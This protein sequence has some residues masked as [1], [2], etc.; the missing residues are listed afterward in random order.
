LALSL[1][2]A[3]QRGLRQ[4]L[5][6]VLG[7]QNTHLARA[8]ELR[9]R[10]QMRPNLTG[11]IG[12]TEQQINLASYGFNFHFPGFSIPSIIGPF[13][14]F[15]AR[16]SFS[17]TLLNFQLRDNARASEH[18]TRAAEFTQ[19][20][21]REMVVLLVA[22]GYLQVVADE[23]R[24]EEARTEVK[25]AAALFE[26]AQDQLKAGLAP[27]LDS[28]RSQVELKTEQ[29]RLRSLENDQAKDRLAMA[30]L[31]GLPLAQEYVLSD[32]VPYADLTPPDL[33]RA[34]DQALKTR[35][36]FQSADAKVKAAEAAKR[37]VIAERYPSV[38]LNAD[39]GDQ[40]PSLWNSHG[41]FTAGVSVNFP[42]WVGGRIRSD[43]EERD[44][45]LQQRT[46]ELADLRGRIEYDVRT[47][48]LDVETAADQLQ[49]AGSSVDLARQ[50]LTQA[51]D[52]FS[53]GVADNIEVVQ[54]QNAVAVATTTYIDNLYAHNVAKVSLARAMGM[55]E[56][57][58]KQY[59]GGK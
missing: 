4:N 56:Q 35:S 2:D 26:R 33:T 23:A 50:A 20:D 25:T 24:V 42:L 17:Q 6:L 10:S 57:G 41:T 45:Q 8:Q 40:G 22:S 14:V 55:A 39:Y 30:R 46:A 16:A 29:T 32:K 51:Q 31:I 43:I 27:A 48:L 53:A 9:A 1:E 11:R 37:A 44:A 49:T 7:D 36:D 13:N 58:V 15:D 18:L 3:I 12:D 34:V 19:K 21:A 47:A 59:L 52:R 28:L 38:A 5:G 54:A